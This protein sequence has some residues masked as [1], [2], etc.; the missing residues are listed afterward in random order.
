MIRRLRKAEIS[1][2]SLHTPRHSH[3]S[4]LLYRG[5]S[6]PAV[7]VRLGHA[8]PNVTGRIYSHA[9]PPDDKRAADAWDSIIDGPVQ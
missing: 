3:A 6:L 9:L 4:I 2:G 8:D 5:L 7:S 1:S